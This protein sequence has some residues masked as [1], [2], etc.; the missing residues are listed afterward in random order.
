MK[1]KRAI[2]NAPIFNPKSAIS[3]SISSITKLTS[4]LTIN[5]ISFTFLLIE[6]I[7]DSDNNSVD[8]K[9]PQEQEEKALNLEAYIMVAHAGTLAI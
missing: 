2:K 3:A 6:K 5:T 7:S 9:D 1:Q 8:M 4:T